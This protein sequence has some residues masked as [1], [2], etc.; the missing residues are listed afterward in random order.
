MG[1]NDYKIWE[2]WH[3][4]LRNV[5]EAISVVQKP[6]VNNY[7]NTLKEYNVGLFNAKSEEG[8]QSNIIENISRDDL[9]DYNIHCTVKPL[10]LIENL[11]KLTM[12]VDS[13][14]IRKW[15]NCCCM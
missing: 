15:N 1:Y 12:P 3:S 14:N 10:D 5:W 9:Q 6:L 11:I 8:F 13:D 7:I 4:C 2:G